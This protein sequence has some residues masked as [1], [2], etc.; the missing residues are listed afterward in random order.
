M[1]VMIAN[2]LKLL[3]KEFAL[4]Q[5]D[6]GKKIGKT[7]RAVQNWESGERNPDDSIIQLISMVFGVNEVWLRTGKGEMLINKSTGL[8]F[9]DYSNYN[10][11]N[12]VNQYYSG[13]DVSPAMR[14]EIK[15]IV[16]LMIEYAT[17]KILNQFK[18][19]LLEIKKLHE[20]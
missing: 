6:F 17:P 3:R 13:R 11:A 16:N 14:D 9:G 12:N 10:I 1:S 7:L 15:E 8:V 4:S 2:Q 5:T 20:D 18:D 19:K